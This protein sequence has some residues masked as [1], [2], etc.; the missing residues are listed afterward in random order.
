[1][2]RRFDDVAG[3][4]LLRLAVVLERTVAG[5]VANQRLMARR[6]WAMRAAARKGVT[7]SELAA[8]LGLTEGRV[9]Q[10]LNGEKATP[11]VEEAA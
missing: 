1:M 8:K 3:R 5:M 6:N 2:R 10:V 7:P 4:L 9:R 11:A